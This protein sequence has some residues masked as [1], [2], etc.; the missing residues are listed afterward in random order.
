MRGLPG[1]NAN[2]RSRRDWL[3][4][5]VDC[6]LD[7]A[8]AVF[9]RTVVA[10][11]WKCLSEMKR[12]NLRKPHGYSDAGASL[13]VSAVCKAIETMKKERIAN[14]DIAGRSRVACSMS[15]PMRLP[16]T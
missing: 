4:E 9:L 8:C 10:Q 2:A 15:I 14:P 7:D 12:S 16:S 13:R 1:Q 11:K 6:G 3:S 5:C